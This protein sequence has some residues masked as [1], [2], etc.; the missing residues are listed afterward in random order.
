MALMATNQSNDT[1]ESESVVSNNLSTGLG[2][3]ILSLVFFIGV[4]G[5][6]FIVWSILFR[7]RK[8]SVTCLL[9]LNLAFADGG[10]MLLTPFFTVYLA[11]RDWIFGEFMCKCLF[12]LCCMNMYASIFFITLMSLDR[13]VAVAWP[14]QVPSIRRKRIVVKILI[15]LWVVT[16]VFAI[17][18]VMFRHVTTTDNSTRRLCS[19]HHPSRKDEVFQ[20]SF[21]T[22]FSFI[23]PFT[24]IL[25]SYGYILY[26]LRTSKF[27]RRLRSENLILAIIGAF[28]FFW[29]PY[30]VV[31]II[32]VAAGLA[33][34]PLQTKLDHIWKTCRVVTSALAFLS[35]CA[36]PILYTFVGKDYIKTA[37]LNFMA[38]LFEG[39][40][41]DLT[42]KRFRI[43]NTLSR[44]PSKDPAY[45]ESVDLNK[46]GD[47]STTATG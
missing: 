25:S 11:L 33:P 46:D 28:G 15:V 5:N 6:L 1:E 42:S 18:A 26:R 24:I 35:S 36:N 30:H 16:F 45:L 27:Q 23:V 43:G 32:Q 8:R 47:S 44:Q 39:T 13:L 12:Y 20:Y 14:H 41:Q 19:A 2:T 37:G 22:V 9:I 40:A 3:F 17:P 7:T 31:N 34:L 10:L 21:E 38:K 4:P 29:L